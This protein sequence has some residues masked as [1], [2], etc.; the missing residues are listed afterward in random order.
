MSRSH[1]FDHFLLCLLLFLKQ[2]DTA[3]PTEINTSFEK[4]AGIFT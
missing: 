4:T 2:N 1:L 3:T